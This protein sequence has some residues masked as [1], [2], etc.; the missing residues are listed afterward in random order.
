VLA[1][2]GF[3][4]VWWLRPFALIAYVGM[5]LATPLV[6]GHYFVDVFAGAAVAFLAIAAARSFGERSPA[7]APVMTQNAA[8]A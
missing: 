5:L 4:G 2:W 3:W 1:L 7:G 6:G 8:A